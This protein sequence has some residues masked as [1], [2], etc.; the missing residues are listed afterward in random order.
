M[1]TV[2]I[3]TTKYFGP[4]ETRGSR[5]KATHVTTRKSVTLP[6]DHALDSHDNHATAAAAVLGRE[7]EFSSSIDG[8]GY[9]F[10]VDPANDLGRK[11]VNAA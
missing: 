10:G 5:V 11:P 1:K 2:R 9:V 8:G 7:P 4:T 3:C 6:W